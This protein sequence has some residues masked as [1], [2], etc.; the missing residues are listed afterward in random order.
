MSDT[1]TPGITVGRQSQP[2]NVVLRRQAAKVS[3]NNNPSE[4]RD[5]IT[6]TQSESS[7][8]GK[9]TGGQIFKKFFK[10]IFSPITVLFQHPIIAFGALAAGIAAC[11]LIPVLVPLIGIGFGAYSIYQVIRGV[12]NVIQRYKAG[13]YD[14]AENAFEDVGAG[15]SGALM[16]V[17]GIRA[18]AV[19]AAQAKAAHTAIQA[20]QTGEQI[21]E[22]SA[23]A[24]N[25]VKSMTFLQA[26]NE[27]AS[28]LTTSQGRS[29]L[30]AQLKPSAINQ[31]IAY[32]RDYFKKPLS[33]HLV[34][35]ES[36]FVLSPEGQRRARLT[37]TEIEKEANQVL[38][39][40][41]DDLG[42]PLD[43]RP[44]FKVDDE[45]R[46]MTKEE[47]E[48]LV[49]KEV[50]GRSYSA[51]GKYAHCSESELPKVQVF[52]E[53]EVPQQFTNEQIIER[54]KSALTKVCDEMSVPQDKRYLEHLYI[55][56]IEYLGAGFNAHQY[57]I[58]Y[59]ANSYRRGVCT[60]E[61]ALAHEAEHLRHVILRTKLSDSERV[62]IVQDEI[63]Q[64]ILRGE[65]EEIILRG[66]FCG[67][68]MMTPPKIKPKMR[69]QIVKL[70]K[71]IL[72]PNAD[73]YRKAFYE[74]HSGTSVNSSQEL[75]V[76]QAKIEAIVDANPCFVQSYKGGRTKAI[77]H[78]MEYMEAQST[79]YIA[80]KH[81]EI[82]DPTIVAR[83]R[84]STLTNAQREEAIESLK[85]LIPSLEGN[86]RNQ[87]LFKHLFSIDKKAFNQ[88]QFGPEEI[89]ARN[90]AA[91]FE[92][93]RLKVK[94]AELKRKRQLKSE[95]EKQMLA[96]L[97]ELN[98]EIKRN[99][100]GKELYRA[101]TSHINEPDNL[102]LLAELKRLK[103]E[104]KVFEKVIE[105]K[106]KAFCKK[107]KIEPLPIYNSVRVR[108]WDDSKPK[109]IEGN[110][111]S[112]DKSENTI[113]F[114]NSHL[115][116]ALVKVSLA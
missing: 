17:F 87:Q 52:Q 71:D 33:E 58:N 4:D 74:K 104:Y 25:Q 13:D 70:L 14:G 113:S 29:T 22:A 64:G 88:Y 82:N 26:L 43:I 28:I 115:Q 7:G 55:G 27:N 67:P 41:L 94:M 19:V 10:G 9:F 35:E 85:G 93:K 92:A 101:Y 6:I 96:R 45:L 112:K 102:Q 16:G 73:K 56:D 77:E 53:G 38:T 34:T 116:P 110:T 49:Q 37:K 54:A 111:P 62:S 23:L 97:D 15:I 32:I 81:S 79:R 24:A 12:D 78:L 103:K 100:L 36:D 106:Q 51:Q 89:M 83:I 114:N 44:K 108:G 47:I 48:L 72:F 61:E 90:S 63:I 66:S 69:E 1:D 40:A 68:E 75:P 107:A 57:K 18:S 65:T 20:G 39:E 105:A 98:I 80:F 99:N 76:L 84:Q 5:T 59:H 95:Q 42:I 2:P 109:S 86:S 21:I 30:F 91:K 46:F 50:S 11:S 3:G 8:D 31:R 60:L